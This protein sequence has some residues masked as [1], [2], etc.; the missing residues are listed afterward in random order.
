MPFEKGLQRGVGINVRRQRLFRQPVKAHDL[1]QQRPERRVHQIT[2]LGKQRRQG[3]S[4]VLQPRLRV[5]NRKAHLRFLP[6]DAQLAEQPHK[7][8]IGAVVVD[9][10]TGVYGVVPLRRGDVYRRGMSTRRGSG[11]KHGDL[12]VAGQPPGAG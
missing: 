2:T 4:V 6:A 3:V 5:V 9:D 12:M 1:L 7:A 10:K 8:R 11:L